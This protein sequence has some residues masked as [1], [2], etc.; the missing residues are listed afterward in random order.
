MKLTSGEKEFIVGG[1]N[2][3]IYSI[4]DLHLSLGGDKPMDIFGEV[5]QEH[6]LIIKKNWLNTVGP[7]D[8]VLIPGDVSWETYLENSLLDFKFIDHLPGTKIISKGNHDY[9]WSTPSK[10]NKFI[11]ENNLN[12]INILQ[13]NSYIHDDVAICGTRGWICPGDYIFAEEDSKIYLREVNRLELS[14]KSLQGQVKEIIVMLHYP[15]VNWSREISGF[16]EVMH[17]YGVSKCIYGHLHGKDAHKYGV[18]GELYGIEH[19]LVSCDYLEFQ[20]KL[21]LK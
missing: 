6:H 11:R 20:P 7:D 18:N 5:W 14:L 17:K 19:Y 21:I 1:S 9:W 4:S 12:T 15:S 13:N 3:A 8:L 2:L 16:I 10:M